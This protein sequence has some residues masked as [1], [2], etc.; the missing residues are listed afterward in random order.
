M[1]SLTAAQTSVTVSLPVENNRCVT[2]SGGSLVAQGES[3]LR[4][5]YALATL[6]RASEWSYCGW[7]QLCCVHDL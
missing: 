5:P 1:D 7:K 4:L 6:Q 2:A 3:V